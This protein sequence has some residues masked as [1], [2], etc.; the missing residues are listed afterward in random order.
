MIK[1]I[2]LLTTL[3]FGSMSAG[4]ENRFLITGCARSGTLF[5]TQV[6]IKCGLKVKHEC[7]AEDGVVSWLMAVDSEKTP[8]GPP[9][10]AE[11]YAYIFH[12]VRCPLKT[13]ASVYSNEPP[14]SWAF[15]EEH[16]PQIHHKDSKLVKCVKYWIYWNKAA[17]EKAL[18]TYRLEDAEEA[19]A[20]MSIVLGR[21]L[22]PEALKLVPKDTNHRLDYIVF[23]DW[24]YMEELLPKPLFLEFKKAAVRYGY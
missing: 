16:L 13:I 24:K 21:E 19:L 9:Y 3:A 20:K 8:Y 1:Y 5:M 12:Q 22:S 17:E 6:L 14:D 18:F 15:I 11:D 10:K 4:E 7:R 23:Y 2:I